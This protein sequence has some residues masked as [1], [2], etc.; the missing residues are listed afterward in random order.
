MEVER[1]RSVRVPFSKADAAV[2]QVGDREI[3]VQ[4]VN[5]SANG[6]LLAMLE[7]PSVST[8]SHDCDGS[9]VLSLNL[10]HSVVHTKARV[11][12]SMPGFLAVEFGA[13]LTETVV[14]TFAESS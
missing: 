12:R 7:L 6:A 4:I 10:D 3:F 1:R 9:V 8:F 13:A 14:G 11:I 2:L 5:I